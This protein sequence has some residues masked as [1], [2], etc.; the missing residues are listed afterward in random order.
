M[1]GKGN[2]SAGAEAT[3]VGA[4]LVFDAEEGP[5]GAAADF[6]E[7]D[8]EGEAGAVLEVSAVDGVKDPVEAE[9]G[10]QDHGGVVDPRP[11]VAKYVSQEGISG[12]WVAE[13]WRKV[14]WCGRRGVMMGLKRGREHTPVH[15]EVP[16]RLSLVSEV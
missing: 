4:V 16:D 7:R 6:G 2:V 5:D 9:D 12:V 3:D 10:V 1:V 11:L 14:N 15:G 8:E 13:T